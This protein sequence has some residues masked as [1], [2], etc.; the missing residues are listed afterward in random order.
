MLTS[1]HIMMDQ[2]SAQGMGALNTSL[3]LE[4]EQGPLGRNGDFFLKSTY[5]LQLLRVIIFSLIHFPG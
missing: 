3:S 2:L 1:V 5:N 4:A